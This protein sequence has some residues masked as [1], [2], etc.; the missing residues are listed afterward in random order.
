MDLKQIENV[1]AIEQAGSIARAA[2]K[3]YLTQSA[4]NQQLLKLE[5]ELGTP[6]FER[7]KTGMVPTYAGRVYLDTAKKMVE[8]K[9]N[10]YKIISDI[11]EESSGLIS[12]SYTPERGSLMFSQIFPIFHEKYPNVEFKILEARAKTMEQYIL[13][14]D[15]NFAFT[16]YN[17]EDKNPAFRYINLLPERIVLAVPKSHRL[18]HLAGENSHERFPLLDLSLLKDD[19]FVVSSKFTRIRQISDECYRY[20]GFKPRVLFESTST[21]TMV[22]LVTNQVSPAFIPESYVDKNLPVVYFSVLPVKSWMRGVC[23]L[24]DN[25]ITKPEHYLIRLGGMQMRGTLSSDAA[26]VDY[27]L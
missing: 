14:R 20:A 2:A 24:A 6:L 17:E 19:D 26:M 12:M 9:E 15:V 13:N 1:I 5:K 3:L 27:L 25:Y 11:A 10:T 23:M 7:R 22:N 16:V 18:A 8:M 21:S 4:L